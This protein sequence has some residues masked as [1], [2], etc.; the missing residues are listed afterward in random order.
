MGARIALLA[1]L[2]LAGAGCGGDDLGRSAP[3]PAD[4]V[5]PDGIY[6]IYGPAEDPAAHQLT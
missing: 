1:S 6:L 2:V 4:F 5:G 3:D